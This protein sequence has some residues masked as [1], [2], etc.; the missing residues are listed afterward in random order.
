M[1]APFEEAAFALQIGEI[2]DIVETDYGYHIL[3]LTGR[4]EAAHPEFEEVVDRV[5]EAAESEV[6]NERFREWYE[7]AYAAAV[8]VVEDPLIAAFRERQED[9]DLGLAAF[10]QIEKDGS[11]DEPYLPYIIGSLYET[12][13]NAA[14]AERD[15]LE[16][17]E[18]TDSTARI[19]VLDEQ[20]EELKQKALAAYR[21]AQDRF[22]DD[23][24]IAAKIEGLEPAP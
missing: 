22:P 11:V 21:E 20:I 12:K 24:T 3:L 6:L 16:A 19:S 9:V 8:I 15:E 13:M 7:T 14:I 5:R 23:P 10:E 17:G 18:E 4:Q 1:V 2:S